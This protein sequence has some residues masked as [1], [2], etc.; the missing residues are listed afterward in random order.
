M[1]ELTSEEELA[2]VT[3]AAISLCAARRLPEVPPIVQDPTTWRFQ[4]RWWATGPLA[5]R[6]RPTLK[7]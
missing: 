3:T 2:L 4:N 5:L 6:A 7:R 1:S